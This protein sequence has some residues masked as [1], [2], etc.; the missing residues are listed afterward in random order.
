MSQRH[1]AQF[2]A[3]PAVSRFVELTVLVS[4]AVMLLFGYLNKARCAGAPFNGDGRSVNFDIVKDATVCYSD[5][6]YLWLGREINTHTFPYIHGGMSAD[7]T[8]FGGVV[9]YPVLSGLLMWLGAHGA[10]NDA[11]FLAHSALL[12]APFGLLTAWL[13]GR[14]SG[15]AAMLWSVG[16]PLVL[17]AFHN[18]ELPVVCCAVAAVF[19]VHSPSRLSRR[20][21]VVLATVLLALGFCCKLYPGIF[22]LPLVIHVLR[23]GARDATVVLINP[24][25]YDIRTAAMVLGAAAATVVAVELPFALA[26]YQGWRASIAFQQMRAVDITTNS[27]WYW[28]VRPMFGPD[29]HSEY[30]FQQLV[31][32]ASPLLVLASFLVALW[33]G[34][35]RLRGD[36][37]FGWV[38]VSGAMLCGFLLF[39]KVHSPQYALWLVPFLV[40]LHVPWSAVFG[41]LLADLAL[42]VGVFRFYYVVGVG[43]A[44]Q[45]ELHIVLF[46]VFGRAVLL[47]VFFCWFLGAQRRQPASYPL[48]VTTGSDIFG[49]SQLGSREAAG[50]SL[51]SNTPPD[52]SSAPV[53]RA[54][55][56]AGR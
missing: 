2:G 4:C 18:W 47:A 46:G 37:E 41:Y 23:G 52:G 56:S 44:A 43:G 8:L 13:L 39:H 51:W 3:N 19:V 40:L 48:V 30:A 35:H 22:L 31:S 25:R 20:T 55:S 50:S 42:G 1:A 26:G 49:R 6:Q 9:E 7:G 32:L 17:Y 45:T 11:Q 24:R 21:R 16:P 12:L 27:L 53:L 15:M 28:W 29:A 34:W 54:K 14:L 5:I 38:A 10:H 36:D 33:L